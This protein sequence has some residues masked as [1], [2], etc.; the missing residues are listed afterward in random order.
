MSSPNAEPEG[1]AI[2]DRVGIEQSDAQLARML[3]TEEVTHLRGQLRQRR[4]GILMA[5]RVQEE[6]QH[7]MNH[8]M[9]LATEHSHCV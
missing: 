9:H 8:M 5:Q 3:Q 4:A 2:F 6:A 1:S 7:Q